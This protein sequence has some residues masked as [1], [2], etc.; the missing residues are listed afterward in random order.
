MLGSLVAAAVLSA[1]QMS[2]PGIPFSRHEWVYGQ[3]TLSGQYARYG[4]GVGSLY[5][6][7]HGDAPG[8]FYYAAFGQDTGS[9]YYWR[10]GNAEGSEYFWRYGRTAG[11]EYYWRYGD[12]CL[13]RSGWTNGARCGAGAAPVLLTLCMARLI[14]IEP[15]AVIEPE[16]DAWLE[17]LDSSTSFRQAERLVE[18]RGGRP[19]PE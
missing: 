11:S 1:W 15:C 4:R 10:Y 14:D 13:S 2:P 12:G 7:A 3:S 5:Y 16:L 19:R 9:I 6:L 17:R 18:M 8:S